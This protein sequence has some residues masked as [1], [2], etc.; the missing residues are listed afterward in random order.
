[1]RILINARVLI[2]G[3]LE[4][5]GWFAYE[6]IK[7]IV[8]NH[9]EHEF[10]LV[11]DRKWDTEF[12]F[13]PN[14]I[15]I[16]IPFQSRHPLLWDIHFNLLIP[17]LI[18][19]YKA[20]LFYSP[21]GWYPKKCPVPGLTV[22]HDINFFHHPEWLPAHHARYLNSR[23]PIFAQSATRIAT[24]SNFS[25]SDLITSYSV[26]EGKI[27]VVF[28]GFNSIFNPLP[29]AESDQFR[30]TFNSDTPYFIFIGALH[31]RKNIINMLKSFDEF[32]KTTVEK[33]E[34]V[35]V[36][37]K[38]YW[39]K[40]YNF[41]YENLKYKNDIRFV[42][43]KSPDELNQLINAAEA[44]VFVPSFEGFGIPVL[45]A[46]ACHT[47]VIVSNVTS[48]PE[49]AGNAALLCNPDDVASIAEK[50]TLIYKNEQLKIQL[51]EQ[52]QE[53]L[54]KFS[55]EKTAENVWQALLKT[56]NPEG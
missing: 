3:K 34:F 39:P 1:M 32:R 54:K 21:D 51:K 6:T 23:F 5:I 44:L 46:F 41:A 53:Q 52:A 48:L 47:S 36:G 15:N 19:K 42:G 9:P 45:E 56:K 31:P 50:M 12:E 16:K 33:V 7:R 11:F 38:S 37:E 49:V 30:K 10:V 18:R 20:D 14:A 29:I 4:G 2:K 22:I 24:V 28:N 25:K 43:R 40:E 27:D 55:W 35:I 26:N 13:G 8:Q 17:R